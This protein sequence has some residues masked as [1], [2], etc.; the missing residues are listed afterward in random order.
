VTGLYTSLLFGEKALWTPLHILLQNMSTHDQKVMFDIVLRDAA[1]RFL[2]VGNDIPDNAALTQNALPIAGVAA[3][4]KGL[5]QGNAFLE[6]HVV[7]W[8]TNTSGEYSGLG[9]ETRRAVMATLATSQGMAL[10]LSSGRAC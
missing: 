8:L 3:L 4:V 5:I 6:A 10:Y 2:R 9:L 1:R 7:Q